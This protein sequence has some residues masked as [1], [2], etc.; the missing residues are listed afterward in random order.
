MREKTVLSD[1]D[2]KKLLDYL[3]SDEKHVTEACVLALAIYSG[4]RIS[5]LIQFNIDT[6]NEDTTA[7][8]NMFLETTHKIRTKGAGK[9]G[10]MLNKYIIKDLFLPYYHKY[11]EKRKEIV[12]RTKTDS[13]N[14]FLQNNGKPVK[15]ST[16]RSWTKSWNLFLG[17][18]LYFHA[19][20]HYF[21]TALTK[22]GLSDELIISI[23]G[24]SSADM[25]KIYTDI[26][27]KDRNWDKDLNKL[28]SFIKEFKED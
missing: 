14:L 17:E 15:L 10:K 6:I 8:G 25:K 3:D 22:K 21:V 2:I 13:N 23:V 4:C 27:D 11:L 5:E 9:Q 28:E 1:S 26:D 20:R 18:D 12:K 16:L 19:L 24:W 7:Y